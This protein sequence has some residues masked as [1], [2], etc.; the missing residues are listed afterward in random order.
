MPWVKRPI[1]RALPV[2]LA[3]CVA[4]AGVSYFALYSPFVGPGGPASVTCSSFHTKF[5]VIADNRGFNDSVDHGVPKNYWPVLCVHQGDS[6]NVTVTNTSGEPHGFSIAHY[7]DQG[8][9][10]AGGQSMTFSF[11]A[12]QNG[13][14]SIKC[15]ILCSVHAFMVSGILVVK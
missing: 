6:V 4:L 14:F 11:V 9:S 5:L 13:T 2:V 3:L 1:P 10:V 12:V 8:F 15:N 7:F